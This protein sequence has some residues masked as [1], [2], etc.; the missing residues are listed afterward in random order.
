LHQD[1]GRQVNRDAAAATTDLDVRRLTALDQRGKLIRR[2][3]R[4][5]RPMRDLDDDIADAEAGVGR[6]TAVRDPRDDDTT[7]RRRRQRQPDRA[8]RWCGGIS[9]S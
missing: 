4:S 2:E 6:D 3:K 5:R 1:S 7:L 8:D 9:R